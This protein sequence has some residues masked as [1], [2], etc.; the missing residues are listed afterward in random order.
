[1]VDVTASDLDFGLAFW[2]VA[3][4]GN[5]MVDKTATESVD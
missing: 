1:M 5:L 4:T 3:V 2:T